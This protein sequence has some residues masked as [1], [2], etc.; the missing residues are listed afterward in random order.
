[1]M[2]PEDDLLVILDSQDEKGSSL[3]DQIENLKK[4]SRDLES[5]LGPVLASVW[6]HM[7]KDLPFNGA[8]MS[9][10]DPVNEKKRIEIV[11]GFPVHPGIWGRVKD[12]IPFSKGFEWTT[13]HLHL[14]HRINYE[15]AFEKVAFEKVGKVNRGDSGTSYQESIQRVTEYWSI[16][17][18][19][20]GPYDALNVFLGVSKKKWG[21]YITE[22]LESLADYLQDRVNEYP[23]LLNSA[24]GFISHAEAVADVLQRKY[25]DRNH[26]MDLGLITIGNEEILTNED[27][28]AVVLPEAEYVSEGNCGNCGQNGEAKVPMV[29]LSC[30]GLLHE[31]CLLYLSIPNKNGSAVPKCSVM[32]CDHSAEE[33]SKEIRTELINKYPK[34]LNRE[35]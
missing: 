7:A 3:E 21:F 4:R 13:M 12:R 14:R 5:Q 24:E 31:D 35:F 6:I 25:F 15:V 33:I 20:Q 22:R 34:T 11:K 16:A 1:M 2:E 28:P 26:R 19:M 17:G 18:T 9:I 8:G 27:L 29:R 32:G 23:A 30:G 10:K